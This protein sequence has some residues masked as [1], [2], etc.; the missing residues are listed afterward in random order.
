MEALFDHLKIND[1]KFN[2]IIY[3]KT[4]DISD[5]FKET[6]LYLY[7]LKSKCKTSG[8]K[9]LIKYAMNH[10]IQSCAKK[11]KIFQPEEDIDEKIYE[12][13]NEDC[14]ENEICIILKEQYYS[15]DAACLYS[16]A[17]S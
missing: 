4:I 2:C 14:N 7:H 16:F 12:F 1:L 11:N 17:L 13:C 5:L 6:L 9:Q 15:H 3:N 10:G 8:Q